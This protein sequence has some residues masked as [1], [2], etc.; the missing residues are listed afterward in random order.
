MD[1]DDSSL[2][3]DLQPKSVGLVWE[4]APFNNPQVNSR[5]GCAISIAR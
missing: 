4:L 1:V 3:A 2:P 5:N